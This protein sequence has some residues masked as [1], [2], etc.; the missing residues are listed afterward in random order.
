MSTKRT[1]IACLLVLLMGIFGLAT[2]SAE[3]SGPAGHRLRPIFRPAPGLVVTES[4]RSFEE[5]WE[6]L[7]EALESNPAITI[8]ALID[9]AAAARSVGLDLPPTRLV[10]FGNPVL[11]TP[12][13]QAD[14]PVGLDLP[15]KMLAFERQGK[16]FVAYNAS[17]YLAF[18]H[19]VSGAP[20]LSTIRGALRGLAEQATGGA[21][22]D[23]G[24]R[25]GFVPFFGG[26][27]TYRSPFEVDEAVRRLA[28]AIAA[29]P[30]Q[31]AVR[32]DHEANA[33]G[34]GLGLPATVL[35]IFGNPRLGTPLMQASPTAAIDLPLKILVWEDAQ[36]NTRVTTNSVLFLALRH[37]LFREGET[38]RTIQG[39]LEGF[40]A[41][42]TGR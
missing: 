1:R 19:D 13:M 18:R 34:V 7:I 20:T 2:P 33:L 15:Q 25:V 27:E 8:A 4:K 9:H 23:T 17:D 14:R 26:L 35:T 16:V 30:A 28:E 41:A 11:G 38:L 22:D 36:G 32:V 29:S 39:A 10:V 21:V 12:L 5:T 31:V 24:V 42:A 37:R 3:G 6:S 40:I